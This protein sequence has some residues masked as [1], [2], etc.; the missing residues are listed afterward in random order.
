MFP[1]LEA[2][3]YCP[4]NPEHHPEGDVWNHTLLAVEEAAA[5]RKFIPEKWQLGFM[6]GML[7][8]DV[9]KPS[10]T[11]YEEFTAYGHDAAGVEIAEKFMRRLT[12]N[13]ELISQVKVIVECHMRPLQMV[14]G[15]AGASAWRRLHNKC[16]INILAYVC[17]C[18][19]KGS[20]TS[21]DVF[22][23]IME[24]FESIAGSE[25]GKIKPVLMGRHL[26]AAGYKP[27][28]N[29][30]TMLKKAYEHQ[31]DTGC[32]DENELLKVAEN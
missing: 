4:Q 7:L 24:K 20:M 25:M 27:G 26:I 13:E 3:I 29:F 23:F 30:S 12:S 10:T 22:K 32:I 8:H 17:D 15:D 19:A 6:F 2:L 14:R 5:V 16:P 21:E 9:G 18:D 11:D 31:I 1:E 28:I